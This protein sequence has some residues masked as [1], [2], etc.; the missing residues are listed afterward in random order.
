MINVLPKQTGGDMLITH[1]IKKMLRSVD[2]NLII[3]DTSY[4]RVKNRNTL[5]VLAKLS[6]E[7]THYKTCGSTV[8]YQNNK[9]IIVKNGTKIVTVMFEQF[10]HIP[11]IMKL[12]KQRY[13][14]KNCSS[15]WTCQTYFVEKRHSLSRQ[16]I[17]KIIDLLR[18]KVSMSFIDK[19]CCISITTVSRVLKSMKNYLPIPFKSALSEVL[20]VDEFRSHS[21]LLI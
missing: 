3:L 19:L 8:F 15:H 6:V 21:S 11:L 20:M 2:P 5:V 10:N 16:I 18:E 13:T 14:C 9:Q 12:A 7:P 1:H 17:F 4:D